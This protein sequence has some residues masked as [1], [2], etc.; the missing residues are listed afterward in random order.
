MDDQPD[1][2]AQHAEEFTK[3]ESIF[4]RHR[5]CLLLHADFS[6]IYVGHYLRLMQNGQKHTETQDGIFK[7]LLAYFTLHLVS[8]PWSEYH[9]WTL[10]LCDP[11]V[12]N[13]FVSGSSLTEDVVGRTFVDDIK[14]PKNN[15]LFAQNI[16]RARDPQ[17]S[18]INLNGTSI[19]HWVEEYYYQSEQR[20]ARCFYL[21]GDNYALISAEPGADHDWL[22]S[23][24]ADY[25]NEML[26]E[27][28]KEET[29]LLETRRFT[30]R[31]GC[32]VE[33]IIPALRTLK[34]DFADLLAKDG[35]IDVSCPR[36]GATHIITSA[37]LDAVEKK[38]LRSST[39]RNALDKS[40]Q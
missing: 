22:E 9:A 19:E 1:Q 11:I 2:E 28:N 7:S 14:E 3:V 34:H 39:P 40:A 26:S 4:V 31:C 10:N 30:F 37:M 24:T 20:M 5:N 38:E 18:I 12:A 36:C 25:I 21:G 13:I 23:L 27:N 15:L 6:A 29:K 8:R 16:L 17:T 35:K 33:K 32:T